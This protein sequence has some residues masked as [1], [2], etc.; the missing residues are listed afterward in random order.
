LLEAEKRSKVLLPKGRLGGLAAINPH[1]RLIFE[2]MDYRFEVRSIEGLIQQL[3]VG[4]VARGYWFYV[5]GVVPAG[6][7]PRI[8]DEKLIEKYGVALSPSARSRRK[9][10]GM[11]NLQYV[12]FENF[13]VLL[14]TMGRHRFFEEEAKTIRDVRESPIKFAGY[15]ISYRGGHAHVRIEQN[16]FNELK[17]YLVEYSLHRFRE[18]LERSFSKLDF[19][20]YAPVRSQLLSLLRAVNA[21]RRSAGYEPLSSSCLH[22]RRWNV[23]P[24]DARSWSF[25][26]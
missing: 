11:A 17:A 26:A 12:R 9:R 18:T 10:A 21:K 20:A 3:A 8:V 13:F 5:T 14:A 7:D 6:K 15:S 23:R 24:F 22:L 19:A 4:Y 2:A 16:V 1:L 25:P